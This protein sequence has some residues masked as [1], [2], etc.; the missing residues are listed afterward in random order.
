[1]YDVCKNSIIHMVSFAFI[2]PLAYDHHHITNDFIQMQRHTCATVVVANGIFRYRANE[3]GEWLV[4]G[5]FRIDLKF[6][7]YNCM[8]DSMASHAVRLKN[9]Y[10]DVILI[11]QL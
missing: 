7:K 3:I 1:M 8:I 4:F 9:T 5:Q 6:C 10:S 11:G 2:V